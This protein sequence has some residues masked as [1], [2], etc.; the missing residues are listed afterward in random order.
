MG[1]KFSVTLNTTQSVTFQPSGDNSFYNEGRVAIAGGYAF[2]RCRSTPTMARLCG[3]MPSS[4]RLDDASTNAHQRNI[5]GEWGWRTETDRAR[6][7]NFET[8]GAIQSADSVPG[9]NSNTPWAYQDAKDELSK[10]IREKNLNPEVLRQEINDKAKSGQRLT[11]G[12]AKEI[13]SK[14]E[15][16]YRPGD[17]M[18]NQLPTYLRQTGTEQNQE[19]VGRVAAKDIRFLGSAKQKLEQLATTEGLDSSRLAA[20]LDLATRDGT[21]SEGD[22]DNAKR[23]SERWSNDS[24]GRRP[25]WV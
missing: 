5:S 3:Y 18:T 21:L 2:N 4:R 10:A 25:V 6:Q 19:T 8:L 9:R 1:D 7:Q 17:F 12:Q 20:Y 23:I 16:A 13:I 15:N 22:V 14:A 24:V 11:L